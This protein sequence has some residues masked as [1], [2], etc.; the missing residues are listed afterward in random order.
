MIALPCLAPEHGKGNGLCGYLLQ[1]QIA[2][3]HEELRGK[4][5]QLTNGRLLCSRQPILQ[6][7]ESL[8][9]LLLVIA[10]SLKQFSNF[11]GAP[12]KLSHQPTII[13]GIYSLRGY[14]TDRPKRVSSVRGGA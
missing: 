1:E 8:N 11:F 14:R 4:I 5:L 6:L 13:V 9:S 2:E 10:S 12:S 3:R 7:R